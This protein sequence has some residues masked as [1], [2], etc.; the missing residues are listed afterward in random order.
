MKKEKKI[1]YL[2]KKERKKD[3][4]KNNYKDYKGDVALVKYYISITTGCTIE[5]QKW[6]KM[7]DP[8]KN[9]YN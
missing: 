1:K 3:E 4:M 5:L 7:E 8:K 6:F 2:S 9:H